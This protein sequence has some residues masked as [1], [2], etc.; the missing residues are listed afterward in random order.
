M[1][2]MNHTIKLTEAEQLIS[3]LEVPIPHV[4]LSWRE[5]RIRWHFLLFVNKTRICDHSGERYHKWWR[6]LPFNCNAL[7]TIGISLLFAWTYHIRTCNSDTRYWFTV[8]SV[9]NTKVAWRLTSGGKTTTVCCAGM[10]QFN[11]I[12]LWLFS[13]NFLLCCNAADYI[14]LTM[15]MI[16]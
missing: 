10:L 16:S 6:L 8:S 14:K 2:Y 15:W 11:A 4:S 9:W 1:F 3:A 12:F 5:T 7:F 13:L